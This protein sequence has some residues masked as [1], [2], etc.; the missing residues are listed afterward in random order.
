MKYKPEDYS[1]ADSGIYGLGD[2]DLDNYTEKLVKCRKHHTCVSCQKE[3]SI[4]DYAIRE[5]GF[6]DGSSVSAYTC[7][8]CMDEWLD[9]TNGD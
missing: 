7:I 4:G 9:K 3:I 5:H 2:E 1:I 6:K 8:N